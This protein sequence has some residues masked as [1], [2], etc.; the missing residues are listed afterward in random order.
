MEQGRVITKRYLKRYYEVD[1][2]EE[3]EEDSMFKPSEFVK[4]V[5][6]EKTLVLNSNVVKPEI[7]EKLY[8]ELKDTPEKPEAGFASTIHSLNQEKPPLE[9]RIRKRIQK[10]FEILNEALSEKI[11]RHA[12]FTLVLSK[13]IQSRPRD[14]MKGIP[15]KRA[16]FSLPRQHSKTTKR[17]IDY[18]H[19]G[20]SSETDLE[21]IYITSWE[22]MQNVIIP[23]HMFESKAL[24]FW[25]SYIS[26][27]AQTLQPV[28]LL[29]SV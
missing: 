27:L 7:L 29:T 13:T 20:H 14:E 18:S 16:N 15:W 12:S 28:P 24:F 8:K 17:S 9:E 11:L 22:L 5:I 25:S 3:Q 6:K 21:I 26:K 10:S 23:S 1:E 19:K 4:A 2:E